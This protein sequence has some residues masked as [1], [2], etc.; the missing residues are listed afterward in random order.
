MNNYGGD[1]SHQMDSERSNH[2]WNL[3]KFPAN[4][5]QHAQLRRSCDKNKLEQFDEYKVRKPRK[6]LLDFFV[7]KCS[8]I[9]D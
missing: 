7:H 5:L 2:S 8:L 6:D 1:N 4:F 9:G 3:V